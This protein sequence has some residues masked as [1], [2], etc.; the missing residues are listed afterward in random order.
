MLRFAVTA[1]AGRATGREEAGLAPRP[2]RTLVT[3]TGPAGAD[4]GPFV[5]EVGGVP[6][7]GYELIRLRGRGGFASVWEAADPVGGRVAIKFMSTAVGAGTTA[8]EVKSLQAVQGL[9]HPGLLRIR[10]VWSLPGWI[11]IAMDL[12]EASLLDLLQL[13]AEEFGRPVEFDKL[14]LYLTAAADALDF[15][16]TRRHRIDGKLVALQHGDIKPNNIL[17]ADDVALL[18]DYGLATPLA[19]PQTPC[20]R[21]GTAEYCAPEVFQ[22]TLTDRS[23][24]FS[25]AVTYHVLRTGAFPYPPP[26][27]PGGGLKNYVRPDPDLGALP[28]AERP[29]LTRAL[30]AIPQNRYPT[31]AELLRRLLAVNQVEAVAADDGTLS[32][33]PLT[34]S[35]LVSRSQLFR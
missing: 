16:N 35:M 6:F 3:P 2:A 21:Q 23:D 4:G 9:D 22:G 19:G 34:E 12:A 26:P 28:A 7:P 31:C 15:L 13:Y 1:C 10:Q 17:L 32:V 27:G 14:A 11:A 24:Q 30:A 20:A 33:R 8:R 29:I 25:L 5:P 18:A